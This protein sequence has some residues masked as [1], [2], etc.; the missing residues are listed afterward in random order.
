VTQPVGSTAPSPPG[1]TR[2]PPAGRYLLI[3]VAAVLM[4][5]GLFALPWINVRNGNGNDTTGHTYSEVASAINKYGGGDLN[6]WQHLYGDWFGLVLAIAT[7]AAVTAT[8]V[9]VTARPRPVPQWTWVVCVLAFVLGFASYQGAPDFPAGSGVSLSI[10]GA[11]SIGLAYILLGIACPTPP[12][13]TS[14]PRTPAG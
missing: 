10:L 2:F 14:R 11:G 1:T 3:A 13:R 5:L 12:P 4:V 8:V 7:V 9:L 6:W